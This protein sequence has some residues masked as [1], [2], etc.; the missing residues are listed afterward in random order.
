[1]LLKQALTKLCDI[2]EKLAF[3]FEKKKQQPFEY[4]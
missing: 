2:V 3:W 1:M 4:R